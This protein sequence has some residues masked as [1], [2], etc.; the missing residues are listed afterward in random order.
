VIAITKIAMPPE[1]V[2]TLLTPPVP[3]EIYPSVRYLF[4]AEKPPSRKASAANHSKMRGFR[5]GFGFDSL[6]AIE[7]VFYGSKM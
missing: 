2:V 3:I 6:C 7:V 1:Y 4:R 5:G